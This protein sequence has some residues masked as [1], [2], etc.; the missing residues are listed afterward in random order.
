MMSF[1]LPAFAALAA[2]LATAVPAAAADTTADSTAVVVPIAEALRLGPLPLRL[3][4]FH[5]ST[6]KGVTLDDIF[7]AP[8]LDPAG[9]WPRLGDRVPLPVGGTAAWTRVVAATG[10]FELTTNPGEPREAWLA[11]NLD[12]ARWQKATL[13]VTAAEAVKLAAWLDGKSIA[14]KPIGEV[15]EG[16]LTLTAGRHVLLVH[17]AAPADL[18]GT[19]RLE[20]SLVLAKGLPA[21]VLGVAASLPRTTDI[22][23]VLDAPRLAAAAISPDG[24]LMALQIGAFTP[25]GKRERWVEVRRVADGTTVTTWPAVGE[26]QD[27]QWLPQGRS[28]SY[29]VAVDGKSDLWRLDV[30]TGRAERL[31]C[32][33]ERMGAHQWAPDASFVVYEVGIESKDDERKVKRVENLADRQPSWRQRSYLM[34]AGVPSGV[35]QRITAGPL[36]PTGWSIAP[37]GLHLLFFREDQDLT[38]RPYF[39]R[40]LHE[41]DLTT[42]AVTEVLA[43]RWIDDATYAPDGSARLLLRGSPS[44]FGGLGLMLPAGVQPNDYGGQ[45]YLYDRAAKQA[46]HLT[47][48]LVADATQC[49]WSE[50]D[51][52]IYALCTDAI[53]ARVYRRDPRGGAAWQLVPAGEDEV[54]L[55][56]LARTAPVA[57]ARGTGANQ[58]NRLHA[59]DL[60]KNASRLL[61]DPGEAA[62]RGVV[63]GKWERWVAPL[64]GGE[65]LDGHVYYPV[66]FDPSRKYPLI[67]F[68]YGGTSPVG[69]DF[70]SRYP[71]EVWAAQGYVV[72]VP[73]PSGATGYGQAF[74]ARH[75]NDWGKLTAREVIASTQ[76]FL[77]AHAFVDPKR[78]GCIGA[79]YGGF[80]TE[81]LLTQT[82]MFACGIS[83]AGISSIS[84][85]WGEGL[86][87]Y[88]YGARALANAFPWQDREL[89]IEQ[90]PLFHADKIHTPLLLLHGADDTNVPVGESDQ[91]F[92][93][94]K[95]LGRD[96]EYVQ[97]LGQD[98]W[99]LDHDQRIV[100]NDTILA[101]FAK[102]LK[103]EP[104]SWQDMYPAK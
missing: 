83:H 36:S 86:W 54:D 32:A 71:R 24:A 81:Y 100:W 25:A 62:W 70:G 2:L 39:A 52:K 101:Y 40:T 51:G 5:D 74:A 37:D 84:S 91:L 49:W 35:A 68:Y 82:D 22:R 16:E 6:V 38:A 7:A 8:S 55:F 69:V 94:L 43:D 48:D 59:I 10:A 98:H 75:V 11:A 60:R 78:V 46:T 23:L 53:Y 45:L 34:R 65:K 31:L 4:A 18:A 58:P 30:A 92:T 47:R 99:I 33:I 87:G 89:Y 57:I 9:L 77:A 41:V 13:R 3:P 63:F 15:R 29:I 42:L 1:S 88:D 67:V 93:A 79:S 64:P 85:Y 17:S 96:V 73:E 103:G 72:Y 80:L 21:A 97:V 66:D 19:W 12:A 28:L 95:L 61:L 27:L 56:D 104:E 26:V 20:P 14:L 44:A 50:A 90:S 76:A 102:V